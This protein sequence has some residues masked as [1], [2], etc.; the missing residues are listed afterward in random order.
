MLQEIVASQLA[1]EWSPEQIAGW[2]TLEFPEQDTMRVSHETIYRSLFLQARGCSRKNSWVSP[3]QTDAAAGQ[4]CE[5]GGL[6]TRA[7]H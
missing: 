4:V 6:A 7:D 2:L 5:Y 3:I 1:L